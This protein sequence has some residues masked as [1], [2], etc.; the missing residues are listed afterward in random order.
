MIVILM[1]KEPQITEPF[2][3]KFPYYGE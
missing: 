1:V 2:Y 3:S